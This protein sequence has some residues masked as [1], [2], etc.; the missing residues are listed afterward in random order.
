MHRIL[1]NPN[2]LRNI[3]Y[4]WGVEPCDIATSEKP[5]EDALLSA[6]SGLEIHK[7]VAMIHECKIFCNQT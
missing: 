1:E 7:V 6:Q 4:I 3:L 5:L 2:V